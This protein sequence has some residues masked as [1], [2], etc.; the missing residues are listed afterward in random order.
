MLNA[1]SVR[2]RRLW[3]DASYLDTSD[4]LYPVIH[5]AAVDL[6]GAARAAALLEPSE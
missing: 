2:L 1:Q 4:D 6:F 3:T 5:A